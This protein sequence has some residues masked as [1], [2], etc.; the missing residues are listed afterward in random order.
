MRGTNLFQVE[1]PFQSLSQEANEVGT[2]SDSTYTVVIYKRRNLIAKNVV[3]EIKQLFKKDLIL[4]EIAAKLGYP[5]ATMNKKYLKYSKFG[6]HNND[7]PKH[8]GRISESKND[9]HSVIMD[10]LFR[11]IYI[12]FQKIQRK[13]GK[14]GTTYNIWALNNWFSGKVLISQSSEPKQHQSQLVHLI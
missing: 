7:A 6:L 3:L 9:M 8:S 2:Q 4:K 5:A 11:N 1:V 13:L 12:S 14:S 10:L